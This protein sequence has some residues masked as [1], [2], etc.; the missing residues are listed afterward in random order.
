MGG[1]VEFF[2]ITAGVGEVRAD[3]GVGAACDA[4]FGVAAA[5][6]HEFGLAHSGVG[7]SHR[8]EEERGR[9]GS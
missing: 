8:G 4:G 7:G 3:E 5:E 6:G 2:L 1:E 9:E